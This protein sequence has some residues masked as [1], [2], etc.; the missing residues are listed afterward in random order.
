MNVPIGVQRCTHAHTHTHTHTH[1][2]KTHTH[3]HTNLTVIGPCYFA[4]VCLQDRYTLPQTE[5]ILK[6]FVAPKNEINER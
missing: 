1:I 3:T 6:F 4:L 2:Q 5:R